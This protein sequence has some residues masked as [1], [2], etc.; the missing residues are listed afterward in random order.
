MQDKRQA[1][2]EKMEKDFQV[3]RVMLKDKFGRARWGVPEFQVGT[4][5]ASH[6]KVLFFDDSC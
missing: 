6:L 4:D 5:H 1:A 3:E 2:V